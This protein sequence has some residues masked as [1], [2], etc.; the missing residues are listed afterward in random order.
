MKHTKLMFGL[1]A[2]M[3]LATYSV[4]ANVVVLNFEGIAAY[5]WDSTTLFVQN[6]YDG[7][8]ASNGNIGPNFGV[9]F[10]APALVI[11][12]N[13]P[14]TVCSNTSRG[15]L[16][17]PGSQL[18][19]L[20]FLTS[21]SITMDVAGGFDTGFSFNY[22]AIN[23]GGSVSVYDGPGG[24]GTLLG[25]FVLPTTA[26]GCDPAYAA[27]FCPFFPVGVGFAG[28]AQSV[29]FAGVGNQIVFDDITF[30]SA[31]PGPGVPEPSTITLLGLGLATGL[32]GMIRRR[33]S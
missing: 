10:D 13:T 25:S 27:G 20:F 24:G 31:T 17:D 19:A 5:P 23:V 12:L 33:R 2:I 11:C 22:T 1:L 9:T 28:T 18:G 26:S 8:A 7:G 30:G 15:G 14:G 29:V 32:G 3:I 6:Y 4:Q 21:N 16:G